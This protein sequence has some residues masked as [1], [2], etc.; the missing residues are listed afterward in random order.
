M[1]NEIPNQSLA[2]ADLLS[3]YGVGT[4][5][6]AALI[7]RVYERIE[8]GDRRAWISVVPRQEASARAQELQAKSRDIPLH[9]VPFAIKD[10]IAVASME[11]TAACP[12]FAYTAKVTAP[13]VQRL[14]D[15]GA[16]LVGK[17]NMDQFATGLVG[18]RSP[19]GV[20]PNPFDAR[21]VPGGSNSG[22]AVAVS[23]GFISFAPGTDTAGSG[24]LP[25][26][27]CNIVGFKPTRGL[28]HD[29]P[30]GPQTT[31]TTPAERFRDR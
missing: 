16:V 24:R 21:Y 15:A 17:T 8:Q 26:A 28:A 6:P 10:N 25:A 30:A 22:S 7:E 5:Q 19:Y 13:V 9:G 27:F 2:S 11:T 4:P 23:S 1:P 3:Q 31:C 20:P 12:A 29:A 18:V 14:I